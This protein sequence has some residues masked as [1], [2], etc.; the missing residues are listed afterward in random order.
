MSSAEISWN[1]CSQ[2]GHLLLNSLQRT[3]TWLEESS[4]LITFLSR[5][6]FLALLLLSFFLFVR[7]ALNFAPLSTTYRKSI[8]GSRLLSDEEAFCCHSQQHDL[9]INFF[10]RIPK[11]CSVSLFFILYNWQSHFSKMYFQM[12]LAFIIK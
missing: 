7:S 5:F 12:T 3:E 8:A 9:Y 4:I 11:N 6:F 10:Q 2:H 1:H